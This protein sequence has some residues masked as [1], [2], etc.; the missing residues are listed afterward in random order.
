MNGL[1]KFA[2]GMNNIK[3]Y[4]T[5]KRIRLLPDYFREIRILLISSF[6]ATFSK[7]SIRKAIKQSTQFQAKKRKA[8]LQNCAKRLFNKLNLILILNTRHSRFQFLAPSGKRSFL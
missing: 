2:G 3:K 1:V 7:L 4:Q 8:L 5:N 6:A